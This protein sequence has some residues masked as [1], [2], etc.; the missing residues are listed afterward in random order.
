MG[1]RAAASRRRRVAEEPSMRVTTTAVLLA[2]VTLLAACDDKP[3]PTPASSPS[4]SAAP[5]G[6]ARA[7][8]SGA[9]PH[10][11]AA[12][13]ALA[14]DAAEGQRLVEQYECS[15][16]H[17]GTGQPAPKLAL[18]C[19]G[20]HQQILAGKFPAS[21]AKLAEWKPH[22]AYYQETPSLEA[23]GRRLEPA[24]LVA[25]LQRPEDVRPHLVPSMPRLPLSAEQATHVAAY[26][27]R[28]ER[29]KAQRLDGADPAHGRALLENKSCGSCHE[30]SGVAP[31][32]ARPKPGVGSEEQQRAIRLA[33]D[34]RHTRDRWSPGALV[35]WLL[36][37]ERVKPGTLMPS[38]SLSPAEARDLA[39]YLLTTPLE[40]PWLKAL[41]VRLPV[42]SRRVRYAEVVEQVIGVTCRHCHGDAD[43]TLGDGGPGNTGGFGFTP[44]RMDLST[45][46]RTNAGLL[47]AQGERESVFA[48]LPDGTP[49]LVASLI[50][51][52]R[53]EAGQ[54]D[55]QVRGMP[56]GL[57]ALSAEQVQLVES[58]VAQG[59]PR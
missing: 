52:Q 1:C 30:F 49:R 7:L 41:P 38:H 14:G 20:C 55:P 54:V 25:F 45:Y 6:G 11:A 4:V 15:R 19:V 44:R 10:A 58:W 23:L 36:E 2:T 5:S 13:V 51:R 59:R 9:L 33:P 32:T 56:L 37:P 3:T 29:P 24:Y 35:E 57:P 17:Q 27:T 53:E 16:C 42:L 26:L 21:P 46:E 47:N 34:L 18:D 12:P 39:A 40:P 48:K 43:L 8:T 22:V 31:L 50:A 28:G